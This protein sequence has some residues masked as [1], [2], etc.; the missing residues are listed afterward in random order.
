[1]AATCRASPS[2]ALQWSNAAEC[3]QWPVWAVATKADVR[4]KLRATATAAVRTSIFEF[5]ALSEIL[6]GVC[7]VLIGS[8]WQQK[9]DRPRLRFRCS[10]DA[11][12]R[13][14]VLRPF[15][16]KSVINQSSIVF[17][18]LEEMQ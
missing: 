10:S 15:K 9:D 12:D 3:W 5:A 4:P 7:R 16:N 18:P 6:R 11:K 8:E 17:R 14:I 2:E 13:I 1:M